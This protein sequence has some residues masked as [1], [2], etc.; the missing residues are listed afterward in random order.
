MAGSITGSKSQTVLALGRLG[1]PVP[2]QYVVGNLEDARIAAERLG[3]P[4]VVKPDRG[5]GG[6]GI[7]AGVG[8]PGALETAFARARSRCTLV[9][10]EQMLPGEDH[11][12][13]SAAAGW[14]RR[15]SEIA[16]RSWATV[17]RP[18]PA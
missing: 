18:L 5:T 14:S 2:R 3:Y 17:A 4:V 11:R 9:V 8:S 15:P 16:P 1:L 7:T 10:V 12:F 6:G 13:W